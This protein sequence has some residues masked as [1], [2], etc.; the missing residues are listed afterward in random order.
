MR[1]PFAAAVLLMVVAAAA[2]CG[3][4]SGPPP[5]PS[6]ATAG[7]PTGSFP[8]GPVPGN[9]V[10]LR[11]PS[12]APAKVRAMP[13]LKSCGSEVLFSE[14][15]DINPIPTAPGPTTNATDNQL[16]ADCLLAA[17]ESGTAAELVVSETSDEADEILSIY[18]LPGNGTLQ[19]VVRV[20]SH[21]D[22]TVSWTQRICRQLSIQ[23]GTLT[24][25]DCDSETAIR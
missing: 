20:L 14:D 15:E 12:D 21:A 11:L 10:V 4:S 6:D 1:S 13:A 5:L 18:R 2:A 24:P 3:D 17:W 23:E 22:R 7:A 16:A 19:L 9:S 8:L 25:A